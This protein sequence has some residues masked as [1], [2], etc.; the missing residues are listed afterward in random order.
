MLHRR[1]FI[2]TLACGVAPPPSHAEVALWAREFYFRVDGKPVFLLGRN[3]TGRRPEEFD[4]LFQWASE[5]GE[6]LVR[7]HVTDVMRPWA[8][9]GEVDEDWAFQWNR[10]FD[11]AATRGL[12]VLP[13]LGVWSQWN[14]GSKGE[15]WHS[16]HRNPFNAQ[17]GGPARDPAELFQDTRCRKLWLQWLEKIAAHWQKQRNILGWEIFSELDLATGSSEGLATEFVELAAKLLRRVDARRRPVTASLSGVREWPDLFASDTM[18][19]S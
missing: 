14:D 9:P 5:A 1:D 18:D 19:F 4:L 7:I 12:L 16:W 3:A 2:A 15:I 17:M 8:P 10:V 6:K 13:V 11:M